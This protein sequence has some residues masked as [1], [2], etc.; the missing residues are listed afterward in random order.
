MQK[1][2]DV[3]PCTVQETPDC[4]SCLNHTNLLCRYNPADLFHFF[5]IFLPLAVTAIGG[6]IV[7]GMGVYLWFWLA[8]ALFFFFIWEANVLC[9]HCPYW[10][11]PS[12]VLH[13]NANY[14]VIKLV[15]YKPQ[16]MSRSEQVQFILGALILALFPVVLLAIARQYL[17]TGICFVS[18]V[19]FGYLL[20]RN[21]CVK[22]VNFSC[23]LNH[24]PEKY[25]TTYLMKNP[26]VK[27]ALERASFPMET[28]HHDQN[29]PTGG[30]K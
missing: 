9:S 20:H 10:V 14:G 16:P 8:Y 26:Q 12:R 23:P 22:C 24:V 18:A 29:I 3:L 7:S 27:T 6:A 5:M 4:E 15:R 25:K 11:E 21:I 17:L 1:E 2:M 28:I 19:N 13:C 30:A